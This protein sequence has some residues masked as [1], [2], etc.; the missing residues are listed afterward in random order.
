MNTV[1][2]VILLLLSFNVLASSY[3][4]T[5][6]SPTADTV[7][8]VTSDTDIA[9]FTFKCGSATGVYTMN[10]PTAGRDGAG[11]L[12]KSVNATIDTTAIPMMYCAVSATRQY[13]DANGVT[14]VGPE[15]LNSQ[16]VSFVPVPPPLSAP[17]QIQVIVI[18]NP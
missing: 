14:Q 15:S 4:F 6:V 8:N 12:I 11:V 2:A 1:I 9:L 10:F 17:G 18:V 16:E 7:G 3:T 5:A 13:V